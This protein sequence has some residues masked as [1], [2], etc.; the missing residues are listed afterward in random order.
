[1]F[2]VYELS[3]FELIIGAAVMFALGFLTAFVMYLLWW[4][5]PTIKKWI[6]KMDDYFAGKDFEEEP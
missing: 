3:S 1:M 6:R 4:Y 5:A 2:A